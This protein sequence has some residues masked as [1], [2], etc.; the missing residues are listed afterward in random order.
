MTTSPSASRQ[1]R[2][3]PGRIAPFLTHVVAHHGQ[4]TLTPP[5]NA[6]RIRKGGKSAKNL[7]R[8]RTERRRDGDEPR[9]N[10]AAPA[11]PRVTSRRGN[12]SSERGPRAPP[13]A[14][15]RFSRDSM[16]PDYPPPSFQEAMM[17]PP[18]IPPPANTQ[19]SHIPDADDDR[20][21]PA[22][23]TH[24]REALP[25]VSPPPEAATQHITNETPIPSQPPSPHTETTPAVEHASTQSH[26]H[27]DADDWDEE[28]LL[29]DS[30]RC[31]ANRINRRQQGADSTSSSSPRQAHRPPN[32]LDEH[33]HDRC[34][35]CASP[36]PSN[37]EREELIPD[38]TFDHSGG[39]SPPSSPK[40]AKWKRLF[41]PTAGHSLDG[42]P[43]SPTIS[44]PKSPRFGF[45]PA[46][47]ASTLTL[48]AASTPTPSKPF[49]GPAT[50]TQRKE[51]SVVRRLFGP[52]G[53]ERE[54]HSVR[55]P[56]DSMESWEVIESTSEQSEDIEIEN[57][58]RHESL[59]VERGSSGSFEG[60]IR[61]GSEEEFRNAEHA[62]TI[63]PHPQPQPSRDAHD[64]TAFLNR[65]VRRSPQAVN[66]FPMFSANSS[67]VS[68]PLAATAH[69][70]LQPLHGPAPCVNTASEPE[71]TGS[72]FLHRRQTL[73]TAHASPSV[74]WL[75]LIASNDGGVIMPAGSPILAPLAPSHVYSPPRIPTRPGQDCAA[76][77]T[78]HSR[79]LSSPAV[80]SYGSA[81]PAHVVTSPLAFSITPDPDA[82]PS[83][84]F[85]D[86]PAE[87]SPQDTV[88]TRRSPIL[89]SPASAS[90]LASTNDPPSTP[91]TPT[92]HYLG[93]PLPQ[94]PGPSIPFERPGHT[95]LVRPGFLPEHETPGQYSHMTE[96][97]LLAARVIDED[98]NSRRY[99]DLLRIAEIA[100]PAVPLGEGAE[101]LPL[102]PSG[103]VK[104]ERRRVTKDGRVKLKLTLMDAVVDKCNICLSQFKDAEIAC[105]A[106]NCPHAFHEYC[107][108]RWLA[109][110]RSCPLCRAAV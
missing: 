35:R 27:A 104:L 68:L 48:S 77:D 91:T 20:P 84:S 58:D 96:L 110:S 26:S 30:L 79:N 60:S 1:Q 64:H 31:R 78:S 23:E 85:T 63:P 16:I 8:L 40:A 75:P 86:S 95:P 24:G 55:N 50:S 108:K 32:Q 93:R 54:W 80:L 66:H 62:T 61:S 21:P 89:R 81:R 42:A 37:C 22:E 36:K 34:T 13:A 18:F 59:I 97:D 51:H 25:E 33:I 102:P 6:G 2:S 43:S 12:V 106:T 29:R 56:R 88:Y 53:K 3:D 47:L 100:G 69:E 17:T 107:L 98:S 44:S 67:A 87:D 4:L 70:R 94:L 45:L 105:L 65:P 99:E 76:Q 15:P 92:R 19:E 39:H 72:P 10:T 5:Q 103:R 14:P 57:L 71:Q 49:A 74:V 83:P 9:F 7:E 11:S 109:K 52:K 73:S 90:T 101:P 46:A 41:I 28:Q 38:Q 82:I